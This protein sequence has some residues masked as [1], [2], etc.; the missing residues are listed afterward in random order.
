MN[1]PEISEDVARRIALESD[2]LLAI[3]RP[4]QFESMVRDI[5]SASKEPTFTRGA[6]VLAPY[7]PLVSLLLHDVVNWDP[8]NCEKLILAAFTNKFREDL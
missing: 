4:L 2:P 6:I 5:K 8:N 1:K 7:G 3:D